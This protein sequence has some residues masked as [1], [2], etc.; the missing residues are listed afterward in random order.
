MTIGSNGKGTKQWDQH[1]TID[2]INV[3]QHYWSAKVKQHFSPGSMGYLKGKAVQLVSDIVVTLY[4]L[5]GA[6][7]TIPLQG[8]QDTIVSAISL[9]T[10]ARPCYCDVLGKGHCPTL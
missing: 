1:S 4:L 6:Q 9:G 7:G 3:I 5:L 2:F 8:A 10:L